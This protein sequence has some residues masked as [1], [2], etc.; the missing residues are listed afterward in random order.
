MSRPMYRLLTLTFMIMSWSLLSFTSWGQEEPVAEG[1]SKQSTPRD[2]S[3]G[4]GPAGAQRHVPGRWATFAVNGMNRTDEDREEIGIAMVG[5]STSLQYGRKFWIP[6]HSRRQAW[7]SMKI[8]STIY[9]DSLQTPL[10]TIH[11]KQT[12]QG[13]A[14]ESNV[15]GMPT[16]ERSLLISWEES[17]AAA[18]LDGTESGMAGVELT[19]TLAKT[20]YAGRDAVVADTQDLGLSRLGGTFLPPTAN[21]LDSLDQIVIADDRLLKDTVAIT[22]LRAWLQL[23]GRVWIMADQISMDSARALLGDPVCY[24]IVD[25]VQMND[26][27]IE[28]LGV[29]NAV[30][31]PTDSWSSETPV[32]MLRVL[33]DTDDVQCTVNGWP[34]AFWAQVGDGE[35]LFTTLGARGWLQ[36]DD[37]TKSLRS[38][39]SRFFVGKSDP[40]KHSQALA[41]HLS[42]QIGYQ[43]PGR[44]LIA[45]VLGVH[46][47]LVLVVGIWL[48]RRKDL[49]YM[50]YL[51]PAAALA[52]ATILFIVGNQKTNAVPSTIATG[53]LIQAIADSSQVKVESVAAIYSQETRSIPIT[54]APEAVTQ[55]SGE[56]AAGEVR[57]LIW[58]DSGESNWLFVEQRQG[59]VQHATTDAIMNLPNAWSVRG[60]FTPQGFEGRIEGID[61]QRC[62]DLVLASLANPEQA[63][64]LNKDSG[65]FLTGEA[66]VLLPDQIF[67][68]TLMSDVQQGR[69]TLIRELIN[70]DPAFLP[71]EPS[72]L[73]WTDPIEGAVTLDA[74]YVRRGWALAS[75]PIRVERL[76][77]GS[78]FVIPAGFLKLESNTNG[79][80]PSTVFNPMTG[81]WLQSMNKPSDSELRC[82]LPKSLLPCRLKKCR[83]AVKISAPGRTFEFKALVDGQFQTFHRQD[84]PSGRVEFEIDNPDALE[85]D[86]EGGFLIAVTVSETEQE[87]ENR[88]RPSE[89]DVQTGPGLEPVSRSTW[90][91]DYVHL[92]VEGTTE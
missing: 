51:L 78:D 86:S 87:R 62:D 31:N 3:V 36:G 77:P 19:E 16:S 29:P 32:E 89:S 63:V 58:N 10:T 42:K 68:S 90:S 12:E 88:E 74:D 50:G 64:S 1:T 92:N 37:P 80:G 47:L 6:A 67:D 35:V 57:R 82:V 4:I 20:V 30:S 69:Q 45:S 49:Q 55:I 11:L 5:D 24:S 25:R 33:V 85:I 26:L 61:P 8:P 39:A 79:K 17:R 91:I 72:L 2:V 28:L 73:L 7:I 52:A 43:I 70:Q 23:G 48:A 27:E 71:R 21:P 38:V 59:K 18:I 75:I 81:R 14:F 56:D 9:A 22:R 76:K 84:S 60:R 15:V 53:Q 34:A 40:M 66:D 65:T 46:V 13:E 54:T 44:G 41:S 83:V